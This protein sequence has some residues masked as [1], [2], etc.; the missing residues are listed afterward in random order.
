VCSSDLDGGVEGNSSYVDNYLYAGDPV[1]PW[2]M[3][4]KDS[5]GETQVTNSKQD[6]SVSVLTVEARDDQAQEDTIVATWSGSAA[7]IVR[8]NPIDINRQ[9][10]GDMA[11]EI[12]YKVQN[13]DSGR[14]SLRMGCANGCEAQFDITDTI[15]K[16][17]GKGWQSGRIKLRCFQQE[18][19][20]LS[21]ITEPLHVAANGK[22]AIQFRAAKV[23]PNEGGISCKF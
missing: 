7:L 17:E 10:T 4:L 20:D 5:G 16:A 8:G 21:Q 13:F 14:V 2:R 6:S 9:S 23:V 19:A 3:L 18:G 15:K 1:Q 11:L 22:L 12:T